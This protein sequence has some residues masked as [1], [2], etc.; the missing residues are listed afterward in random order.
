MIVRRQRLSCFVAVAAA[1]RR[2]PVGAG[3]RS[4]AVLLLLLPVESSSPRKWSKRVSSERRIPVEVVTVVAARLQHF[5][6]LFAGPTVE[7][8]GSG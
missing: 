3:K 2:S 5:R 1:A 6:R 8:T 4:V 7:T